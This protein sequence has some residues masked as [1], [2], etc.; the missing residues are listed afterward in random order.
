MDFTETYTITFEGDHLR[1][2]IEAEKSIAWAQQFWGDIV[3]ACKKH[4]SY[5]VLGLSYSM[6]PMPFLDAYDHIQMF[7]ELGIDSKYRIAYV[8][9]NP[10]AVEIVRYVS[11][12]FFNRGIPAR[13]FDTEDEARAWLFG[14]EDRQ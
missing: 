12:A 4:N 7:R 10:Q 1:A 2:E 13:L 5:N 9:L 14:D 6:T 8:E 3:E 11:D